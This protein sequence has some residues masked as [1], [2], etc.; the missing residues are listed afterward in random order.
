MAPEEA[1]SIQILVH[2]SAPCKASDDKKLRAQAQAILGYLG[3]RTLDSS[4][5]IPGFHITETGHKDSH[6]SEDRLS[7]SISNPIRKEDSKVQVIQTPGQLGGHSC[8]PG[9]H[10]TK[11]EMFEKPAHAM[12]ET[13]VVNVVRTPYN[14]FS[15]Y[16]KAESHLIVEFEEYK[17]AAMLS[18]A[19]TP[20]S[21]PSTVPETAS[22]V[23]KSPLSS[24]KR[25]FFEQNT[26]SQLVTEHGSTSPKR[27]RVED[28][29]IQ[30]PREPTLSPSL[31]KRSPL[32]TVGNS[33]NS[34]VSKSKQAYVAPGMLKTR[35][36]S[37]TKASQAPLL[38]PTR[39]SKD[40][41]AIRNPVAHVKATKTSASKPLKPAVTS[42]SS[43]AI[44]KKRAPTTFPSVLRAPSPEVDEAEFTTHKVNLLANASVNETLLPKYQ[45]VTINREI[46]TLERGYWRL[47]IPEDWDSD[48][49]DKFHEYLEQL[50][51]EG[52]AGWGTWVEPVLVKEATESVKIPE[53]EAW[54]SRKKAGKST[55]KPKPESQKKPEGK[56]ELRVWCW[57]EVVREVWLA[58]YLGG[59]RFMK[60]SGMSWIDGEGETVVYME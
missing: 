44:K 2:I 35:E 5:Y 40:H 31:R 22:L 56:L 8:E 46:R 13:P 15:A 34:P 48:A 12:K 28:S 58:L 33:N 39:Q 3:Q 36:N 10:G 1:D 38:K 57:G 11:L 51:R 54:R 43:Y 6:V 26:S 20:K 27:H 21:P 29:F 53:D 32:K 9:F 4:P 30:W 16:R 60:G 37:P 18:N 7:S 42:L 19:D 24:R 49:R 50:I 14:K 23:S 45:P 52:R 47:P 25:K 17:S 41:K 55:L 59:H